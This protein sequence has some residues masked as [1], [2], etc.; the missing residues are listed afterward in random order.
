MGNNN[1]N[2]NINFID[3]VNTQARIN[4]CLR[5]GMG[6]SVTSHF[7]QLLSSDLDMKEPEVSVRLFVMCCLVD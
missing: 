3:I 2:K 4:T 7:C 6:F 5:Y 1:N